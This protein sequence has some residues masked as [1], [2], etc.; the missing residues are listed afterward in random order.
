[1]SSHGPTEIYRDLLEERREWLLEDQESFLSQT[2]N[3]GNV[4]VDTEEAVGH[5][6]NKGPA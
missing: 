6:K 4:S 3:G 5:L 1:M 2:M